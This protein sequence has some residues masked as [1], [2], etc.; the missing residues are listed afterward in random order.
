MPY[1][2]IR[3]S[4]LAISSRARGIRLGTAASFAGIQI[5]VIVSMQEGGDRR[6]ADHRRPLSEKSATSGIEREQDEPQQVADD[7]RVAA[8]QPVGEHA[9]DR[10]EDQRGQQPDGDDRQPNASP[11]PAS[12]L[13]WAEAKMAVA[14]RPSQSPKEATPEHQPEPAERPDPQHRAQRVKPDRSTWAARDDRADVPGGVAPARRPARRWLR[15]DGRTSTCRP[16]AGLVPRFTLTSQP[17]PFRPT[18][19]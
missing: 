8:V 19:L 10:A 3:V 17:L 6:P 4:W 7:H 14:S 12:P 11:S 16:I 15:V 13:T 9:G 2:V 18:S 1:V 5:S